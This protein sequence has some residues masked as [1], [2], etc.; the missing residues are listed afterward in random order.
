[1]SVIKKIAATLTG[2]V[3]DARDFFR[4]AFDKSEAFFTEA[5]D[6]LDTHGPLIV[7]M[8]LTAATRLERLIPA[9]GFGNE[10]AIMFDTFLKMVL[11]PGLTKVQ[12]K[13]LSA[14]TVA[15]VEAYAK[16]KVVEYVKERNE[17]GDW[18]VAVEDLKAIEDELK[19]MAE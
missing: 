12:G 7:E 8:S 11:I 10:K 19:S 18:N 13:Q 1:M 3:R 2:A 9:H 17:S 16:E 4:E 5:A 14:E 15:F 6:V